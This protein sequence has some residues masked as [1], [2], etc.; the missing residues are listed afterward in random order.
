MGIQ[1]KQREKKERKEKKRE[2]WTEREGVFSLAAFTF[3]FGF[4]QL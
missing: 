3:S 2:N 4:L 1:E